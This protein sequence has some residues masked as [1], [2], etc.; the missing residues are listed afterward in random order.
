M[1]LVDVEPRYVGRPKR[2]ISRKNILE[3]GKIRAHGQLN[4]ER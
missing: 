3:E 4:Y 1:V 2:V